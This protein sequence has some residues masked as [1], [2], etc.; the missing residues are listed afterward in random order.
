MG[1][2]LL[3]AGFRFQVRFFFLIIRQCA[4]IHMAAC[5]HFLFV[6][7]DTDM[8][9]RQTL[10]SR[11]GRTRKLIQNVFIIGQ[12]TNAIIDRCAFIHVPRG[13]ACKPD[14]GCVIEH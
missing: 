1:A 14:P 5:R 12:C 7:P 6:V 4:K 8:D 2:G 11:I 10:V 9:S 3:V 13:S